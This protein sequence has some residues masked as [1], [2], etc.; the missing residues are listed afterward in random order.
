MDKTID[1]ITRAEISGENCRG[2][3]ADD[4]SEKQKIE[5]DEMRKEL[6]EIIAALRN[7]RG[8]G[9]NTEKAMVRCITLCRELGEKLPFNI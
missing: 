5:R 2:H 1:L 7:P 3:L 4:F 8:S 9:I 6:A